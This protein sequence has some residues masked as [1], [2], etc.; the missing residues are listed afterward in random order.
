MGT[1]RGLSATAPLWLI[2]SSRRP[3]KGSMRCLYG[4]SSEVEEMAWASGRSRRI[5][6]S[7]LA[8]DRRSHSGAPPRLHFETH[9]CEHK[10]EGCMED[11][12]GVCETTIHWRRARLL[13]ERSTLPCSS[14]FRLCS[15]K[16]GGIRL[17]LW[18]ASASS[19]Q[20]GVGTIQRC[21]ERRILSDET[22]S[23]AC[24]VYSEPHLTYPT[25]L[26]PNEPLSPPLLRLQLKISAASALCRRV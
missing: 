7:N 24:W 2:V 19:A 12:R 15:R 16:L 26:A 1:G 11:S 22:C 21:V 13:F 5:E 10:R 8:S 18:H 17:G 20:A 23:L 6:I 14:S 25:F 3:R 9:Q 4:R